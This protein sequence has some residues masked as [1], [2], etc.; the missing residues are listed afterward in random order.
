MYIKR[1]L[2]VRQTKLKWRFGK[3]KR[4]LLKLKWRLAK[5]NENLYV[6]LQNNTGSIC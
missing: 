1:K 3:I 4:R 5:V 2:D 6:F